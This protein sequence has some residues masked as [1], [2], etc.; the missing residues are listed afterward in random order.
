MP[1]KPPAPL[2]QFP[3]KGRAAPTSLRRD[4]AVYLCSDAVNRGT[5]ERVKATGEAVVRWP[6]A[7]VSEVPLAFLVVG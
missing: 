1:R 2:P 6:D 4:D 7:T 3:T 5:V